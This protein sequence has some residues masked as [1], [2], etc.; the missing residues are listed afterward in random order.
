MLYRDGTGIPKD[1]ARA[2][3]WFRKAAEQGHAYAQ[4]S[5]GSLYA[6]GQGV[7]QDYSQAAAWYRKAA[8]Q[9]NVNAQYN[10][11]LLYGTGQGVP[12][13]EA[14]SEVWLAPQGIRCLWRPKMAFRDTTR[15]RTNPVLSANSGPSAHPR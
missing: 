5:L 1:L 15:G 6:Q 2:A 10:L 14:Q 11:A 3:D 13:D 12:E 4:S 7:P 9:G 8:D